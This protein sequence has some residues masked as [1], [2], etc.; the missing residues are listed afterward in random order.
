MQ[1]ISF[2]TCF[3]SFSFFFLGLPWVLLQALGCHTC[4]VQDPEQI[5]AAAAWTEPDWHSMDT[6]C[7][8]S[9]HKKNTHFQFPTQILGWVWI[10]VYPPHT[11]PP[12][13]H[14]RTLSYCSTTSSS[15]VFNF[16]F[17]F[18]HM[19]KHHQTLCSSNKWEKKK[20]NQTQQTFSLQIWPSVGLAAVFRR[21]AYVFKAYAVSL[22]ILLF[23]V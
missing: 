16:L 7:S 5:W 22:T 13:L 12:P 20:K 11:H 4:R 14:P 15:W 21:A 18:A 6:H 17:F 19:I 1:N 8:F 2:D 10:T 3:S 9:N 23:H